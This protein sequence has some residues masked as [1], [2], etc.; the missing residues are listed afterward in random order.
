MAAQASWQSL[1]QRPLVQIL[2]TR[3]IPAPDTSGVFRWKLN[4]AVNPAGSLCRRS[5]HAALNLG[6]GSNWDHHRRSASPREPISCLYEN[7]SPD[8]VRQLFDGTE[9]K[10][11]L[12]DNATGEWADILSGMSGGNWKAAGLRD[13]VVF[14]NNVDKMQ[15][16]TL[17]GG[18]TTIT[19]L[20]AGAWVIA[21]P[22]A[23]PVTKA[24]IALQY[25]GVMVLMNLEVN[26]VRVANRVHW[27]DYRDAEKW[28]PTG[29]S[30]SG[31]QDLDEG[32]VIL[33]ALEFAGIVYVFTD[34]AI[35]KMFVN[36][37]DP[38]K[39]TFGFNRWYSDPV[40]RIACL[41]YENAVVSTGKE[42][43]WLGRD[44]IYW[45]NQFSSSPTS[46]DW[47]LKASG[48]MF[49]GP[50]RIDNAFCASPQAHAISSSEGSGKEVWFSYP[51]VGSLDGINDYS[52]VLSFNLDSTVSPF[53]TADYV[54]HGYTAFCSF[55]MGVS[56]GSDC[57]YSPSFIGAS[58][59]DWCLKS[60][61]VGFAR[62][63]VT[64]ITGDPEVNI[65]DASYAVVEVGYHSI[66]RGLCPFGMPRREK[67]V[68]N[69]LLDHD[70]KDDLTFGRLKIGNTYTLQDCNTEAGNCRVLWHDIE[71][72]PLSCPT[73]SSPENMLAENTRP[74][75]GTEWPM[76]EEGKHLY[77][78]LKVVDANGNP[79]IGGESAWA[80]LAWEV[81]TKP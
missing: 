54:D 66:I 44:T 69:L 60:L 72:M 28:D 3:S 49:E 71:D 4:M 24:K 57:K 47:L 42:L 67:I 5:G 9:T 13:K 33:N 11:S 38:L 76:Y 34:R 17:G 48:T 81:L 80:G 62:E 41:A 23:F 43:F 61:G 18:V 56:A 2:D 46:A 21:T 73:V 7:S 53:Q 51:R 19:E 36:S 50:Y 10:V 63:M 15:V 65:P 30:V 68:R 45:A 74:D 64:L 55:S 58:G 31:Y 8:G 37:S 22:K 25:A 52:L 39:P 27:S 77:Y 14:T 70:T 12:L 40:N 59:T 29:A 35:W 32:E 6:S 26:T 78:E 20:E 16:Y 75:I 79:P 1:E